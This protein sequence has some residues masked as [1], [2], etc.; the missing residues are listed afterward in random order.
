[1]KVCVFLTIVLAYSIQNGYAKV[2]RI[3]HTNYGDILSYQTDLARV[4]F[5]DIPFAQ[6]PVDKLRQ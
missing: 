2:P 3:V 1:M 4:F 5:Y 6:S